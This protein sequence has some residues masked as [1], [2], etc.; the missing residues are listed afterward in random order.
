MASNKQRGLGRDLEALLGRRK[1]PPATATLPTESVVDSNSEKQNQLRQLPI[2][3]LQSGRYQPRQDMEPEALQELA[4]SIR[5]QGVIQ[6]ILVRPIGDKKYEIIAGERRW[7]AS[8]LAGLSDIPAIVN[9]VDDETAS[10]MALIENVQ[11]ED[12]NPMEEAIAY[13]RLTDEFG[14]TH[15]EVAELVGKSRAAISNL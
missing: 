6:P 14:L 15:Q 10:A 13:H 1:A 12:L 9:K 7:R 4:N 11:R 3:V 8:Q 2:D 5:T